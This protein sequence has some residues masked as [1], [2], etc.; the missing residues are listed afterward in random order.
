MEQNE[1]DRTR[2]LH[3]AQIT[4]GRDEKCTIQ[5]ST[6]TVSHLHAV[7][8]RVG[9][10]YTL[11]D[12]SRNGT[13]LNGNLLPEG[14]SVL[15]KDR[16]VIQIGGDYLQ[17]TEVKNQ[18]P[19]LIFLENYS[20][21]I[22]VVVSGVSKT[23]SNRRRFLPIPGKK[24]ILDNVDLVIESGE[25]A[26]IVGGSGA[27]KST[28][29]NAISCHDRQYSGMV[30]YNGVNIAE[31]FEEYKHLIGYVPQENVIYENLTLER[32][33]YY[34]AKI[35]MEGNPSMDMIKN[36]IAKV[37]RMVKLDGHEK[38]MVRKL[39]GGQKKRASIAVE[40]L[41]D[42]SILFLDEP[43][44]GLDPLTEKELMEL[45]YILAKETHKTIIAVTHT[46]QRLELCDRI[47]FMGTGGRLCCCRD[48]KGALEF[49]L[50][51]SEAEG[52][53]TPKVRPDDEFTILSIYE[54]IEKPEGAVKWAQRW[55]EENASQDTGI[56]WQDP[57][58]P[59]DSRQAAG[60]QENRVFSSQDPEA[61]EAA[62][63]SPRTQDNADDTDQ[64]RPKGSLFHQLGIL[65]G[66]YAEL[67]WNDKQRLLLLFGQPAIIALLLSMVAPEDV[68][69]AYPATKNILFCLS[70]AGIWIGLFNSIQ[71][72]CKERTILKREYLSGLSLTMYTISKYFVQMLLGL[73]QSAIL[74]WVFVLQIRRMY[75]CTMFPEQGIFA[76]PAAVELFLT[77]WIT[78]EASSAIGFVISSLMK[79]SDRA[80]TMAPFVLIIQLLFS[81]IL[82]ELRG[83]GKI[84]SCL[85]VSRWSV[86]A[87]GSISDLNAMVGEKNPYFSPD[88]EMYERTV[89]H[90]LQCWGI[91][92][93]MIFIC[94]VICTLLLRLVARDKR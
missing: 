8:D 88:P 2:Q 42:P 67:I 75:D 45:L 58:R 24:T 44:S 54:K 48:L 31:H 39:S 70:C 46:T 16:D 30:M 49:F 66:R 84:L 82:F 11:T 4:I 56:N 47:I 68:Y 9:D 69:S 51:G 7:L 74:T 76:A 59:Y 53:E 64:K 91:C 33:L 29:M 92:V 65:I 15:L 6:L 78:V 5:I 23:V 80:M 20:Q 34:S 10:C 52:E 19:L 83:A 55:R 40:L 17:Y 41:G 61:G 36:N 85:T 35:K 37:L 79:N 94:A 71:E 50:K 18:D 93:L 14:E 90:L 27:G 57:D 28:L 12:K 81:G 3:D 87:L 77:V 25:F 13:Y 43:T 89:M 32:M 72:I 63:G 86:A 21:G 1:G 60:D 62:E 38:T 26:A 73:V 22:Q